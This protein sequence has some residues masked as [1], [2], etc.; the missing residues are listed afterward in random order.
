MGCFFFGF[1]LFCFVFFF[2]FVLLFRGFWGF[3]LFFV[4]LIVCL[5]VCFVFF[6]LLFLL[7]LF[8]VCL[9]VLVY[10]PKYYFH[11]ILCYSQTGNLTLQKLCCTQRSHITQH[12]SGNSGICVPVLLA[13]LD[14]TLDQ[15]IPELGD[16]G[17]ISL[18]QYCSISW[19]IPVSGT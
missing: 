15:Y 3:I 2:L 17:T 4:C 11:K 14:N 5:F 10:I 12:V 16:T 9:F 18:F 1:V 8:F 19:N 6:W 13:K 7:L